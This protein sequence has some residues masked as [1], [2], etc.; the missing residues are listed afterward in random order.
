MST[1][2]SAPQAAQLARV[3]RGELAKQQKTQAALAK[4]LGLVS[5]YAITRRM[6]GEVDWKLSELRTTAEFL[7]LSLSDLI[8]DVVDEPPN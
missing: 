7:G 3:I 6:K 4:E 5:E 2:P 8:P 1:A